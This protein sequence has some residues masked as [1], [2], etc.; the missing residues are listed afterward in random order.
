LHGRQQGATR[1]NFIIP[2][3]KQARR[4]Q[5]Q[6]AELL[7]GAIR[8]NSAWQLFSRLFDFGA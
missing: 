4:L 7:G 5:T 2:L 3:A 6:Y 1:E 8:G